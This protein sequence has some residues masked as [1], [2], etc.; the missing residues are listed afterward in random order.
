MDKER[1]RRQLERAILAEVARESV[2]TRRRLV[3]R[4]VEDDPSPAH[5]E[6][7]G[8]TIKHLAALGILDLLG[9]SV[10]ANPTTRKI[11]DLLDGDPS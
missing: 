8:R 9:H 5:R 2:I 1:K 3:A 7:A 6:L 4:L 11:V 10:T